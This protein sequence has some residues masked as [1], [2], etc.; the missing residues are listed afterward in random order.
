MVGLGPVLAEDDGLRPRPSLLILGLTAADVVTP[1]CGV[2]VIPAST[3]GIRT[4]A[5]HRIRIR[6]G[7][8]RSQSI[9]TIGRCFPRR[10]RPRSVPRRQEQPRNACSRHPRGRPQRGGYARR[11]FRQHG[12]DGSVGD[13]RPG[14]AAQVISVGL[15]ARGCGR[16]VSRTAPALR[17]AGRSASGREPRPHGAAVP[18]PGRSRWRTGTAPRGRA[19]RRPRG[20]RARPAG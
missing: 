10:C 5:T 19:A 9:P 14:T 12:P 13:G 6:F 2:A 15:Q 7:S 20:R 17:S 11:G 18:R 1:E 3:L 8:P 16:G 4:F